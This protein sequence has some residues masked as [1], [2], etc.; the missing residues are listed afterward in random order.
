MI[1]SWWVWLVAAAV[2]S[3]FRLW[4]DNWRGP[5]RPDEIAHFMALLELS[6]GAEHTD[7]AALRSFLEQDDGKEFLMANLV[8]LTPENVRHPH[9]GETLSARK[10]LQAYAKGFIAIIIRL[11]GHPYIVTRKTGGYIDAWAVGADPGWS[12]AA[13]MRYRSRRDCMLLAT[14]P[15]FLAAYPLKVL[16]TAQTFSFPASVVMSGVLGPRAAVALILALAAALVHL[17]SLLG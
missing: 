14:H 5:L 4:Y 9:T 3:L 10:M 17:A 8:R 6:P 2:Y 1:G 11:G 12:V 7:L 16:A 13:F 15:G